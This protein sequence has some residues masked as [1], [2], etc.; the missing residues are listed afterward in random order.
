MMVC[1][2]TVHWKI[3]GLSANSDSVQ[4]GNP[5]IIRGFSQCTVLVHTISVLGFF[6]RIFHFII[7]YLPIMYAGGSIGTVLEDLPIQHW[8]LTGGFF[9]TVPVLG[10]VRVCRYS[11][12]GPIPV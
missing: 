9:C 2:K 3:R 8:N 4:W 12:E 11:T 10:H 7:E 6:S 1:T 5:R